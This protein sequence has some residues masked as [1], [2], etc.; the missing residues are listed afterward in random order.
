MLS[1]RLYPHKPIWVYRFGRV[2]IERPAD[3]KHYLQQVFGFTI[4]LAR[5]RPYGLCA[6]KSIFHANSALISYFLSASNTRP[7]PSTACNIFTLQWNSEIVKQWNSVE[8][9][10]KKKSLKNR[11]RYIFL[12]ILVVVHSWFRYRTAHTCIY[13]RSTGHRS[14]KKKKISV[15]A[16]F[17]QQNYCF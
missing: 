1:G 10:T 2:V 8:L 9:E 14:F 17:S 11:L 12:F 5:F 15:S 6:E 13:V 3:R 16:P 4:V 7:E